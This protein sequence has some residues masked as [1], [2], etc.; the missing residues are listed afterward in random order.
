MSA[1]AVNWD[2][3]WLPLPAQYSSGNAAQHCGSSDTVA[4]TKSG[5]EIRRKHRVPPVRRVEIGAILNGFEL[6]SMDALAGETLT[7]SVRTADALV[8]APE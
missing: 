4:L 6:D 1:R 5:R 7:P 2:P 3:A 8:H